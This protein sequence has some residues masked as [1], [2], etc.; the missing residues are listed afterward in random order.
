[1]DDLI[2]LIQGYKDKSDK[3]GYTYRTVFFS[4]QDAREKLKTIRKQITLFPNA[5]FR[6]VKY[7]KEEGK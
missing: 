3:L 5:K 2:W 6:I 7:I 1:M 4:R